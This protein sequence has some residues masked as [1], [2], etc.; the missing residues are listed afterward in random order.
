MENFRLKVFRAV[1]RHLNFRVAAEELLLT[2]PAVTQQIK[3]LESELGAALFE[4]AAG[5][6]TLTLAGEALLPYAERLAAISEEAR[7]AVAA[8]IGGTAGSLAVGASQTIG[9]YL[10][11]RLIA[12]FLRAFPLVKVS[13]VGGNTQAVLEALMEH[14][15]QVGL[16]EGPALRKD[17]RVEGFMEDHMV[18]VVPAEHEWADHEI[19]VAALEGATVVTREL[20]SGS[21]RIVEQALV[22]AGVRVRDLRIGMVADSTEGLLSAVEAGLGVGFVSRWAVRNQLALGTLRMVRVK[23]LKLGRMF[24]I[25]TPAG[26]E[27]AGVAGAFRRFVMERAEELAPRPTGRTRAR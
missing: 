23:G 12:G 6:V 4:R 24:S 7:E 26:P 3:A 25:A 5:H 18:C 21:R 1:A 8:A 17:V 16:I 27:P 10:L 9:Q 13:V 2:Q 22:A 19:P 11:P 14:R 20:G 15:V